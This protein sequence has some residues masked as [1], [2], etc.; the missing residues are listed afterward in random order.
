LLHPAAKEVSDD[1]GA[2]P[3]LYEIVHGREAP[4]E[5]VEGVVALDAIALDALYRVSA[6]DDRALFRLNR[7]N[8]LIVL[9]KT[10]GDVVGYLMMLPVTDETYSMIRRGRFV[11]TD[12]RP[13]MV[14][15]Y[16]RPGEY[17]LYFASLVVH[18]EHREGLA[19]R[20]LDAAAQD[21]LDLAGRG[22]HISRMLADAV[23]EDGERLCRSLGFGEVCSTDHHSKI[24]ESVGL[25]PQLRKVTTVTKRLVDVYQNL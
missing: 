15:R 7:E 22:I 2:A 10:T 16:D 3:G 23:S 4:P 8:G 11:D 13:G 12:L 18:P 24:Y 5:S 21:L 6:D 17:D 19:L 25:P 9:E 20:L 14:V 1:G